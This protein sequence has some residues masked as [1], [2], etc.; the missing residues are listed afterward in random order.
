MEYEDTQ[1]DHIFWSEVNEKNEYY[2]AV[3]SGYS[4]EVHKPFNEYLESKEMF[5]TESHN[6]DDEIAELLKDLGGE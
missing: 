1:D 5:N 4:R 3:L 2:L 6:E